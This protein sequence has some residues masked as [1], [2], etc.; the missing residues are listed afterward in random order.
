MALLT[1]TLPACVPVDP[2]VMVTFPAVTPDPFNRFTISV[3]LTTAL[4][5]VGVKVHG[6]DA[7]QDPPEVV[8]VLIVT[9][10]CPHTVSLIPSSRNRKTHLQAFEIRQNSVVIPTQFRNMPKRLED[11]RARRPVRGLKSEQ[12]RGLVL[13]TR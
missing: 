5:A 6:A 10:R 7:L 9:F 3:T 4:S 2:V 12:K 11:D 8:P 1:V 13:D